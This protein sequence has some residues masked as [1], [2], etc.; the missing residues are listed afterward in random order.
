MP[1]F[2][3]I[4]IIYNLQLTFSPVYW[5]AV[6]RVRFLYTPLF[7]DIHLHN[8]YV[9]ARAELLG[10]MAPLK[11]PLRIFPGCSL[12]AP[13]F[14]SA[15]QRTRLLI[16]LTRKRR[17]YCRSLLISVFLCYA[18]PQTLYLANFFLFLFFF[19]KEPGAKTIA[20]GHPPPPAMFI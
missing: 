13:A 18:E 16:V 15:Y 5:L 7:R 8:I 3:F 17:F 20:G 12:A 11:F 4:F 14:C 10:I 2:T 19:P 6:A 1:N 9:K